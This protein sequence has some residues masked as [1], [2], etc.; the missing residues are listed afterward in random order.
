MSKFEPIFSIRVGLRWRALG[1][2]E[3]DSIYWF[4]IGPHAEYDTLLKN[5]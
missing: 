1:L 3:G 5:L 2:I 4:W